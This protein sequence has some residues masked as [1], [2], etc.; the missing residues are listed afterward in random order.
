M[1]TRWL[2]RILPSSKDKIVAV[3]LIAICIGIA[4]EFVGYIDSNRAF[5]VAG[6]I[7]FV[8]PLVIGMIIYTK[9]KS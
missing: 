8:I 7:L 1:L 9:S 5:Y 6:T 3:I 4:A 2:Y